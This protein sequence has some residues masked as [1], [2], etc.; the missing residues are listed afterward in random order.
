ME[1]KYVKNM[2]L[3]DENRK[4][5]VYYD[6]Y[7]RKI[8]N[9][10]EQE[11]K[12]LR[13]F[14]IEYYSYFPKFEPFHIV[15]NDV[16]AIIYS[17]CQINEV[18][19]YYQLIS[20]STKMSKDFKDSILNLFA[21]NIESNE[22]TRC[23]KMLKEQDFYYFLKIILKCLIEKKI[24]NVS[25]IHYIFQSIL[26]KRQLS[27]E[28]ERQIFKIISQYFLNLNSKTDLKY[29]FYFLRSISDYYEFKNQENYLNEFYK[30]LKNN[31]NC[32]IFLKYSK[33]T[34]FEIYF[35]I[36][37]SSKT[38]I[39]DSLLQNVKILDNIIKNFAFDW[40][41]N[42]DIT[43]FFIYYSK[44]FFTFLEQRYP[45]E[46]LLLFY[47]RLFI[48]SKDY[49]S[50]EDEEGLYFIL[51]TKIE[52]ILS[53]LIL[54]NINN[55]KIKKVFDSFPKGIISKLNIIKSLKKFLESTNESIKHQ[56]L[57][58][59][60]EVYGLDKKNEFDLKQEEENNFKRRRS[61]NVSKNR[62][63]F[64][65]KSMMKKSKKSEDSKNN[66]NNFR[67]NKNIINSFFP[68]I[69]IEPNDLKSN[70]KIK[71][72]DFF[73][74][75]L[76]NNDDKDK[77]KKLK[78]QNLSFKKKIEEL[79]EKII[80]EKEKNENHKQKHEEEKNLLKQNH[81]INLKEKEENLKSLEAKIIELNENNKQ[82]KE[83]N[84]NLKNSNILLKQ[85]NDLFTN[86]SQH[87]KFSKSNKLIPEVN[88]TKDVTED[89]LQKSTSNEIY[90][91]IDLF[92]ILRYD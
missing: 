36:F 31:N 14:F 61:N 72:F 70:K 84:E 9:D 68:N 28:N 87:S 50:P 7:I 51:K 24:N 65:N 10:K 63:V 34:I 23:A 90:K 37:K 38:L 64:K 5:I 60:R 35:E 40:K 2:C 13:R 43:F 27:L 79:N 19:F 55:R 30:I 16:E 25:V 92:L 82:L 75:K 62:I 58:K 18:E 77:V 69:K 42:S 44:K 88:E 57:K 53:N 81:K 52:K 12:S 41:K 6:F 91:K 56:N 85:Q 76:K 8:K 47:S 45:E 4:T 26:N 59:A 22:F 11:K 3:D 33:D 29:F 1:Y 74:N 21:S 17:D 46:N 48:F 39:I 32:K 83:I 80:I 71:N 20:H 54:K 67:S 66:K 73:R 78:M 49:Q 86:I 15:E 89:S